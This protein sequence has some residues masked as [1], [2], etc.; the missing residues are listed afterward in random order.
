TEDRLYRE[1]KYDVDHFLES[2]PGISEA[3]T[4]RRTAALCHQTRCPMYIVH[5]S[6]KEGLE[7]VKRL[8]DNGWDVTVETCPQYLLLTDDDTR[9]QKALLKM[10]PPLRTQADNQALWD[11]IKQGYIDIVAS[12]HAPWEMSKK[13]QARD[14]ME[15]PFGAP[16]VETLLPLMYSEGVAKGHI[17]VSRLAQLMCENPARRFGIYPKKGSLGIGADADLTIIDPGVKWTIRG[18]HLHSRAGYTGYEGWQVT[19]RPVI[20][21]RRGEILLHEAAV[22]HTGQAVFLAARPVT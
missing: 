12:D 2:R 11:G 4:I 13:L 8:R 21:L 17:T 3:E 14:F 22:Q 1:G 7:E 20:S 16:G 10:A 5:L 6:S 18:Q 19:G 9:R 15:V